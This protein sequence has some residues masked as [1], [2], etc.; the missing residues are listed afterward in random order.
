MLLLSFSYCGLVIG[1]AVFDF[2]KY[3]FLKP[4]NFKLTKEHEDTLWII[5]LFTYFVCYAIEIEGLGKD[6]EH[7]LSAMLSYQSDVVK[8]IMLIFWYFSIIFF[9]MTF[10]IL[11]AHK[12]IIISKKYIKI[13]NN[14]VSN[15]KQMKK[16]KEWN[17]ISERIW[18]RI[19]KIP[20]A[21]KWKRYSYYLLW[22]LM[23][24]VDIVI[25][26]ILVFIK[27]LKDLLWVVIIGIPRKL[28]KYMK[29]CLDMLEK[30]QGKV[31]IISSRIALVSSL[32]IV[33]CVDKYQRVFSAEGSEVYEF[34]CSVMLIPFLITQIGALKERG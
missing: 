27:V 8:V 5:G 10:L 21:K 7:Y 19:E 1:V 34:M 12:L 14:K 17:R 31:I 9:T 13:T 26:Y 29:H 15:Q 22:L 23:L 30:E 20:T 4:S 33:F 25:A 6:V 2:V 28:W 18:N 3:I 16:K 32:I 11:F 24:V